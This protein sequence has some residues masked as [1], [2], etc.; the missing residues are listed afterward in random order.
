MNV[1]LERARSSDEISTLQVMNPRASRDSLKY[2]VQVIGLLSGLEIFKADIH[3]LLLINV[4]KKLTELSQKQIALLKI[5]ER[6]NFVEWANQIERH[7]SEAEEL[8]ASCLRFFNK[9]N[10]KY[11]P[12]IIK[13]PESQRQIRKLQWNLDKGT[14]KF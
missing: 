12:H 3:E 9:D 10:L 14:G 5:S 11:L 7:F 4:A 6:R 1:T 13:N 2:D 8:L